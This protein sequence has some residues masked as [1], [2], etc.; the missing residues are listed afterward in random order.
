MAMLAA[1]VAV[2]APVPATVAPIIS[3]VTRV[4]S[5][6]SIALTIFKTK[7]AALTIVPPILVCSP[8]E[9]IKLVGLLKT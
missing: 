4:A 9:S 5:E 1:A 8:F 3:P 6:A 2:I 7:L